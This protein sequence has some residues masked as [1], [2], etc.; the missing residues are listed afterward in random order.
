MCEEM[1]WRRGCEWF[2]GPLRQ[3]RDGLV[4]LLCLK[5]IAG[6]EQLKLR[7]VLEVSRVERRLCRIRLGVPTR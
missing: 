4:P 3:L 5:A 1:L 6:E 7:R 2:L